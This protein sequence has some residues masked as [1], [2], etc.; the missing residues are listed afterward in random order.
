[1]FLIQSRFGENLAKLKWEPD[2]AILTQRL[3]LGEACGR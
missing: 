1:M 3:N 2:L